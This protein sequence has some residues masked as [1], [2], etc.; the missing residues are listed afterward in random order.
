MTGRHTQN[1]N[2]K[3]CVD[4]LPPE[5]CSDV[6]GTWAYDTM[7]RR[8]RTD[9][10]ARV[11][12]ENTTFTPSV[13][14][15]LRELDLELQQAASKPLTY[16]SADGGPDV[17][18]WNARLEPYVREGKTWLTAPWAVAEFYFYRRLMS[19]IDY[20]SAYEDPFQLQKE[21]GLSSSVDSMAAIARR[22][23]SALRQSKHDELIS[24]VFTSLWGNRMDLSLWPVGG[25]KQDTFAS[26]LAEGTT[27][28]LANDAY[29]LCEYVNAL[30][31]Q[32]SGLIRIDIVVDNAGFE[33]FCDLCLADYLVSRGL[34]DEVVLQLKSHPTFVSDAMAKDVRHTAS[35][36]ESGPDAELRELG[37]RWRQHIASGAWQLNE[38][39]FWTQPWPMWEMSPQLRGEIAKHSALVFVKGDANYRRLLGDR[40]WDYS[41][42]AQDVLCYWPAPV[43][44]LRTLKAELGCG[45]DVERVQHAQQAD[46]QWLVNGRWGVVQFVDPFQQLKV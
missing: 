11:V 23:N 30:R 7:S 6:P 20:F 18:E 3:P 37:K 45:M 36:L 22:L 21:L 9:I 28:L 27:M 2:L 33:L 26:M 38:H 43:C 44:A 12:R 17:D 10:L 14:A 46:P 1:P 16:I 24:F 4:H 31:L 32:E 40:Q 13:A 29:E 41:V 35:F 39:G 19:V 8:I 15:A 34:C 25:D 42:P 5:I